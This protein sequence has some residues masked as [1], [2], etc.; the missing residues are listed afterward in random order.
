MKSILKR[1]K[2][3]TYWLAILTAASSQLPLIKDMLSE[4][5][6]VTALVIAVL[7]A[8]MREATDKPVS[9]K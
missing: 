1:F 8:A 6:G 7:I 5:Y 2:S 9:E 4:Y 3:K